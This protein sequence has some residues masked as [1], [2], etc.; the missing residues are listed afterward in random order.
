MTKR[1]SGDK[2]FLLYTYNSANKLAH[3]ID[4]LNK[5]REVNPPKNQQ[6]R[7]ALPIQEINYRFRQYIGADVFFPPYSKALLF[8]WVFTS[9]IGKADRK[10]EI[11][12][13]F[14]Y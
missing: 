10:V 8:L 2:M 6:I 9:W 4:F 14:A 1:Q 12:R 7:S 5:Q 13:D 11:H 3:P